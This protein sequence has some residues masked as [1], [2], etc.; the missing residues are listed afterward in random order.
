MRT[1]L[2]RQEEL[3]RQQMIAEQKRLDLE[4]E[5]RE[6]RRQQS[7]IQLIRDRH[8]KEKMQQISLTAHGKKVLK[9]LD[10]EDINKIDADTIAMKEAEELL[11]ERKELQARLKSQDKRVSLLHILIFK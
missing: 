6:K 11:K 7:E 1:F 2:R 4:R 3:A 5:E 9:K 10:D 8:L